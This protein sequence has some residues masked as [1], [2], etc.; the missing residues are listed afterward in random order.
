MTDLSI[1]SFWL[2]NHF[3]N[4]RLSYLILSIDPDTGET[5]NVTRSDDGSSDYAD[6]EYPVNGLNIVK[7]NSESY[8]KAHLLL[9]EWMADYNPVIHAGTKPDLRIGHLMKVIGYYYDWFKTNRVPL[10]N[11]NETPGLIFNDREVI[12]NGETVLLTRRQN[13]VLQVLRNSRNQLSTRK[14]L[15]KV[16]GLLGTITS[17]TRV[18][19]IFKG[20]KEVFN[21]CIERPSKGYYKLKED[22]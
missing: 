3:I 21:A 16:D 1:F 5:I 10:P 18:S 4:G 22:F 12:V 8:L 14:I 6:V 7:K 15:T 19:E 11:L 20:K 13:A 2:F 9:N 17:Y